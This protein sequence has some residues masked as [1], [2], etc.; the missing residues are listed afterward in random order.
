MENGDI[1]ALTEPEMLLLPSLIECWV[2][3]VNKLH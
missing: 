3:A 1:K 2:T